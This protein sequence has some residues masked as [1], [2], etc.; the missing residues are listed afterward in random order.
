MSSNYEWQKQYTKQ[1]IGD[2]HRLASQHRAAKSAQPEAA[3]RRGPLAMLVISLRQRLRRPREDEGAPSP[4][5][6]TDNQISRPK[7]MA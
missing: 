2:A 4:T 5:V 7:E 6:R 1:R 3:R